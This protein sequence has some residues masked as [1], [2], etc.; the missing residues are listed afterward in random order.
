MAPMSHTLRP[1]PFTS[2]PVRAAELWLD[3]NILLDLRDA[4]LLEAFHH[5]AR[6]LHTERPRE[7]E[8][9]KQLDRSIER[10]D[11]WIHAQLEACARLEVQGEEAALASQ[12]CRLE[13]AEREI[14][15]ALALDEIGAMTPPVRDLEAL[16]AALGPFGH[17]PVSLARAVRPDAPLVRDGWIEVDEDA[18]VPRD[19][20]VRIGPGA[21]GALHGPT[22]QTQAL[23]AADQSALLDFIGAM[24]LALS[25]GSM[26]TEGRWTRAMALEALLRPIAA[27]RVEAVRLT[28]R[29]HPDWPLAPIAAALCAPDF[30]LF[31]YVA[32]RELGVLEDPED[33]FTG[34]AI[35]RALCADAVAARHLLR[36]LKADCPLRTGGLL[37]PCDGPPKQDGIE[38]GDVL[39]NASWEITAE[40]RAQAGIPRRLER[41]R[42]MRVASLRLEDLV[43]PP[44]VLD[45]LRAALAQVEHGKRLFKDWGLERILPY[46]RGVTLLFHGPPGT[47]KTATAEALA[48][49]LDRP[50]LV[51]AAEHVLSCWLGESEKRLARAFSD[52]ARAQAVLFFDEADS[53]FY[54]RAGATRSW[55][56]SQAN[57]LLTQIER[58]DGVC[59]LATNRV[60]ALDPALARRISSRVEFTRPDRAAR[61]EIW[62]RLLRPPLPV[63]RKMDLEALAALDLTGAEIKTAVLNA[64]RSA[65]VN[66]KQR[67]GTADLLKAATQSNT[68]KQMVGFLQ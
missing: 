46:G 1:A 22:T 5:L 24:V 62:R 66:A 50:L 59:I 60:D 51:V 55:E 54:D 52:A 3:R 18:W 29:A 39:A 13:R 32:G 34:M 6:C 7:P 31:L 11:E 58:F 27:R 65:L 14:V 12:I 23:A 33:A 21:R 16:Q 30:A 26:R 42:G 45:S 53:F 64:A 38:D 36:R 4:P 49:E 2:C 19:M 9:A 40:A 10:L 8:R 56:V 37:T 44:P 41:I 61:A 43:L 28:L 48:G 20:T 63:A 35:T 68:A 25:E 15:L 67:L 17:D 57:V 47:G